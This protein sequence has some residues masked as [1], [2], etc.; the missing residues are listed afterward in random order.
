MRVAHPSRRTQ[1]DGTTNNTN[2][3]TNRAN[4]KQKA[5]DL[6]HK[7]HK[8]IEKKDGTT[9]YTNYTKCINKRKMLHI[10][11]PRMHTDR[12]VESVTLESVTLAGDRAVGAAR[13]G[14]CTKNYGFA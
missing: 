13:D 7:K 2:E 9:N 1:K 8:K 3:R 4:E 14:D 12:R 11:K 6:S 5:R 10:M